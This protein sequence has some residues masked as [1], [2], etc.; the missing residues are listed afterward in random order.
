MNVETVAKPQWLLHLESA[1]V[2]LMLIAVLA[3]CILGA[4]GLSGARPA[5]THDKSVCA[6]CT[7]D[8]TAYHDYP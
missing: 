7:K 4:L 5:P 1:L 2:V 8:P 3:V 6:T